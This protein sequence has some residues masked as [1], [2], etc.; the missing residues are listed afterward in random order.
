MALRMACP[1]RRQRTKNHY[2]RKRIP[3]DVLDKI[4]GLKLSIPLG[5]DRDAYKTLTSRTKEIVA[6]LQTSEVGRSRANRP[7]RAISM[8]K[9]WRRWGPRLRQ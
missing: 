8:P 7:A 4:D 5:D 9:G 1:M 6:S 3:R 2:L